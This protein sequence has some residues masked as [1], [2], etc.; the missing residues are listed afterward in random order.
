MAF[1]V[2]KVVFYY[3][4][5]YTARFD[6][7][8]LDFGKNISRDLDASV[9]FWSCIVGNAVYAYSDKC[10]VTLCVAVSQNIVAVNEVLYP[11]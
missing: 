4:L 10:A 7:Q 11:A 9:Y 1:S 8:T 6:S 3:Q 5:A 2:E